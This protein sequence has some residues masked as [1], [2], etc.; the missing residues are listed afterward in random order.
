MAL[1]Y[2]QI[3]TGVVGLVTLLV[4]GYYAV[5]I[6]ASFRT[7]ILQRGWVQVTVGAIFLVSAQF[8][9]LASG[10]GSASLVA[11]PND[12]GLL[13]RFAGLIFLTL[14]LRAHYKVWH[15]QKEKTASTDMWS[16]PIEP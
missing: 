13:M 3:I 4:F 1:D 12:I 15:L 6:L 9:I 7:G 8:T 14:G 16:S 2:I 10:E 5:R 11:A